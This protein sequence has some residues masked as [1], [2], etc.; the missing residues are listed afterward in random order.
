MYSRK[1]KVW[2]LYHV[3]RKM[4]EGDRDLEYPKEVSR[5][6]KGIK[7]SGYSPSDGEQD[8]IDNMS[9]RSSK[10]GDELYVSEKQLFWLR[11]IYMKAAG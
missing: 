2:L 6:L 7:D 9:D 10:W 5:L 4:S 11:D 1:Q 8:F 3:E